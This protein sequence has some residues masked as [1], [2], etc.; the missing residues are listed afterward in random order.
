MTNLENDIKLQLRNILFGSE[1]CSLENEAYILSDEREATVKFYVKNT[2][3]LIGLL[4]AINPALVESSVKV[5]ACTL[6][7]KLKKRI[8]PFKL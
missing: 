3:A 7:G 4:N 1:D 8:S 5:N 2:D 6:I